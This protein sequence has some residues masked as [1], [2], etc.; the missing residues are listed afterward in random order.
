MPGFKCL[1]RIEGDTLL[2]RLD[3]RRRI[4][5]YLFACIC[6]TQ[7]NAGSRTFATA[8]SSSVTQ[9]IWKR[10]IARIGD[11]TIARTAYDVAVVQNPLKLVMLC[12]GG[13][14]LRRSDRAS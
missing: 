7:T 3:T 10:S 14:I 1:T 8:L 6:P 12:Q 5:L 11:L 13:R 9:T 2:D 4:V